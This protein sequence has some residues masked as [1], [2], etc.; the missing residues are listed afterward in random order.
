VTELADLKA[1]DVAASDLTL[2][3]FKGSVPDINGHWIE[4]T[5]ELDAGLKEIFVSQLQGLTEEIDYSLLA[6]NNE[7]SVLTLPAD[8]TEIDAITE[9]SGQPTPGRKTRSVKTLRNAKFYVVRLVQGGQV[10]F[11]VRKTDSSWRT[12]AAANI[13]T[14]VYKDRELDLAEDEGFKIHKS[15]D[16][17][18]VNGRILIA[19]KRNFESVLNYRAAHEGDFAELQAEAAFTDVFAN[20]VH[21]VDFVG[22]NRLQLRRMS[23]IRRK[24]FYTDGQFMTNLRLRFADYGLNIQFDAAGKIIPTPETCRDIM[25]ALLD[26]RLRSGF[27]GNTYDVPNTVRV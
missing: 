14:A 11:A 9:A 17:F 1:F 8:E 20:L 3:T 12:R 27:S 4:T 13:L 19:D 21:L 26:H 22:I 5:D 10:V 25:T 16:F 24:A 18:C 7:E 15:F 23:A 2:W 6:E